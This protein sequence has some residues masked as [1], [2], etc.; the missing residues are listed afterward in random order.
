M[1]IMGEFDK[2]LNEYETRLRTLRDV[3]RNALKHAKSDQYKC[4]LV[5]VDYRDEL[6]DEQIVAYLEDCNPN[7]ETGVD[8]DRLVDSEWESVSR[9]EGVKQEVNELLSGSGFTCAD[10]EDEFPD[11]FEELR[12]AIEDSDKSDFL[13]DLVR[14]TGSRLFQVDLDESIDASIEPDDRDAIIDALDTADLPSTEVN[15][16]A[17]SSLIANQF[18]YERALSIVV[19]MDLKTAGDLQR[20]GGVVINPVLAV[21]DRWVG[22]C[23]YERFEARIEVK[24][25][26]VV[27]DSD[28]GYGSID[29][30]CGV[31]QSEFD[32]EVEI[33]E[34]KEN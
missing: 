15:I 23:H 31:V 10:V 30:I 29:K 7:N 14:N 22:A 5:Y 33:N 20:H 19:Y 8:W 6:G 25:G 16:E 24:P 13:G 1:K 18:D 27:L 3:A 12:E 2:K 26:Q 21:V 28:Q 32:A 34:P 17:A 11:L 9:W 4:E